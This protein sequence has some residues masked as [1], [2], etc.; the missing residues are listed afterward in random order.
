MRLRDWLF[1]VGVG[2]LVVSAIV[3]VGAMWFVLYGNQDGPDPAWAKAAGA[4][5]FCSLLTGLGGFVIAMFAAV[6][7]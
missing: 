1:G 5:A 3:G 7:D 4:T 6:P 2:I